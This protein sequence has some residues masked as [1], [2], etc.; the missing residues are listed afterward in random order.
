MQRVCKYRLLL[1]ELL[2]TVPDNEYPLAHSKIKAVLEK[3]AEA[4]DRIN[5]VVGNPNLRM[6]IAK[7]ISLHERLEYDSSVSLPE[8]LAKQ[9]LTV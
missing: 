7:T 4:V 8:V 5:T 6:R 3:N 9:V 1:N 2:K